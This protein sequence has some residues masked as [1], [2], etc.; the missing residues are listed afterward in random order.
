M[1]NT[2]QRDIDIQAY[3]ASNNTA[4]VVRILNDELEDA[5]IEDRALYVDFFDGSYR[6]CDYSNAT[7]LDP[8]ELNTASMQNEAAGWIEAT[9]PDADDDLA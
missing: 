2:N 8:S 1:T 9:G 7:P 3:L 5:G 6:L 4:D